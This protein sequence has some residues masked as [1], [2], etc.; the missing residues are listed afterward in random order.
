MPSRP[1]SP[2]PPPEASATTAGSDLRHRVEAVGAAISSQLNQVL[3][4]LPRRP[5]GPKILANTVGINIV[6]ASRILKALGQL[7]PVATLQMLPGPKPLLRFVL[8]ARDQGVPEEVVDTAS[9]AIGAF[10]DLIRE[11]TGDRSKFQA[12]LTMWLPEARREFEA[13]RRQSIY[14]ARA[15]LDGV[16]NEFSVTSLMLRPGS[17]DGRNDIVVTTCMLGIDRI[18]PDAIVKF[19]TQPVP[20]PDQKEP[21]A[22]NIPTTLTGEPAVGGMQDIRLDQFCNAPPAP[23]DSQRHGDETRY[24]LGPTGFGPSSKVDFVAS[25]VN[26]GVLEEQPVGGDRPPFFFT[27]ADMASRHLVFD[28]VVHREIYE[29][30][31]PTL[32]VYE[33]SGAGFAAVGDPARVLDIRRMSHEVEPLGSGLSRMHLTEFPRYIK[34]QEFIFDELGDDPKDFRTYRVSIRYPL[35][36]FQIALAF[37]GD[38]NGPS[39]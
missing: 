8:S 21:P 25:E 2:Q 36:G 4:H 30:Q 19:G 10:A 15:E 20:Y 34:L 23:L 37:L 6:A 12:M 9:D 22:E 11:L 38:S 7:D 18:R 27:S 26:R 31:A 33:A 16:S 1:I 17:K 13:E 35:I 29:D 24:W 39:S 14:K 3:G 28:L 5:S 32:F